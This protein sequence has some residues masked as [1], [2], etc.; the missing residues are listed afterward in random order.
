MS[1]E[2]QNGSPPPIILVIFQRVLR[3][4]RMLRMLRQDS[5]M[6]NLNSG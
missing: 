6:L 5:G 1:R 2:S 3:M 4:L